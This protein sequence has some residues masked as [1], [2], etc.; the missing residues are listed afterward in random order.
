M[1]AKSPL[2]ASI[3]RLDV[4]ATIYVARAKAGTSTYRSANNHTQR[5]RLASKG[6]KTFTL[7]CKGNRLAITRDT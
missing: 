3:E 5:V 7:A 6:A 4:G 2:R 1:R